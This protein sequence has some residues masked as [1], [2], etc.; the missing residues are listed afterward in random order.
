MQ[1][2]IPMAG[3]GARF[4]RAGYK[5]LKPLI[6]V[7]GM[8]MIEHVVRMFPGERD[9]L[10]ICSQNHLE[11]TPL[12]SVLERLV[13]DACIVAIEPHKLGPV[14]TAL[15]AI[16]FIKDDKPVI[17]NY[18][19]FSVHWDYADFK[20][21]MKRLDCAGCITA[22][23]GFH[24]HSLGANLYAY[25]RERNNCLIEIQEKQC[26]TDQRMNEYASSGTYYFRS[27][28]LLKHYFRR[29][30]ERNLQT[31]G[32]YYAS[33]PYNLMVEDGLDVYI[34]E[35]EHFLQWG[36]PEDLEEYQAWSSYFAHYASWKPSLPP[37]QGINLIPMAGAGARFAQEGYP[38]PK[39]LVPVAGAPMV[40]RSLDTLPPA[41]TWI[42]VCR[43]EHLQTPGLESALNANGRKVRISPVDRPTE[44]QACTCLLA[45][46]WLDPDA[47]LL[48]GPCDTAMVYDQERY[49]ALTSDTQVDC[50]VW[51]FRN[52]PHANRHPKQY[53][54]VRATS[55][56]AVQG[57]SCKV[58]LSEDIRHDPGIIGAFWFRQARFFLEAADRLIA[59]NR[60]INNEFY[61]DSAIEVL[62]EQGR[63]AKVFDVGHYICFGTPDDV[64]TYEY[65][66]AYFRKAS[67]HSYGKEVPR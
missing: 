52:H 33:M 47:P 32:E 40:Q 34:Y 53:G 50:L 12:R 9:F 24:P 25:M 26:F 2:V 38:H 66:A 20:H 1:I 5:A 63:R 31:N 16:D 36:T 6:E 67:H 17:L 64:R 29:A 59:Q 30:G 39:P 62:L 41:K 58:P 65:W 61:V 60:R 10:F 42:A 21:R 28:A 37:M 48:V 55:D 19:D 4:V 35:L 54:W 44:G 43:S 15:S 3:S 56:G 46:G 23:R 49:A 18:C 14:H 45:R 57:I 13:P 8:P 22:Y 51:T 27:G 11:E 7:D